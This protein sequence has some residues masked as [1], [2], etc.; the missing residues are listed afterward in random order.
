[1]SVTTSAEPTQT[2]TE[3]VKYPDR[4]MILKR[5][6]AKERNSGATCF[7]FVH[8]FRKSCFHFKIA[9]SQQQKEIL[10]PPR[11]DL[12]SHL[13]TYAPSYQ[14]PKC[15]VDNKDLLSETKQKKEEDSSLEKVKFEWKN[16]SIVEDDEEDQNDLEEDENQEEDDNE[17]LIGEYNVQQYE[18]LETGDDIDNSDGSDED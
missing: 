5:A 2:A 1:M 18:D 17:D 14:F 15:F 13:F 16:T 11:S 4:E 9:L 8:D 6:S 7:H 3:E 10:D 12:V